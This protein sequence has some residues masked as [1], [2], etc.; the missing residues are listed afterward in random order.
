MGLTMALKLYSRKLIS[1]IKRTLY[2]FPLKQADA[3]FFNNLVYFIK[4][5]FRF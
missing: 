4:P 5:G 2:D 3:A 1:G